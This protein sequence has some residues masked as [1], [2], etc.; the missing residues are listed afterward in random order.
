MIDP[1]GFSKSK[2]IWFDRKELLYVLGGEEGFILGGC[3]KAKIAKVL[4]VSES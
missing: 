3:L 2:V 4:T 1:E